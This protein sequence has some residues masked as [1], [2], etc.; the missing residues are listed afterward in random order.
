MNLLTAKFMRWLAQVRI[1]TELPETFV[2][3]YHFICKIRRASLTSKTLKFAPPP[4]FFIN[5]DVLVTCEGNFK[6]PYI[7][8]E[9]ILI[10]E[11]TS[12]ST[13]QIDRREKLRAYQQMPSVHEYVIVEQ[14]K[15]A[16]EIHRRQPDARWITY[17]FSRNDT[18]FTL[19]SVDLTVQLTE[20]Y[21]RV[22]FEN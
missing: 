17:F 11:V 18:E 19:E 4:T 15:I 22:D 14:E 3:R 13:R 10:V 16:V 20:V 7:C 5:P 8:E 1:I 6:N 2:M 9:P 21:R 12:P